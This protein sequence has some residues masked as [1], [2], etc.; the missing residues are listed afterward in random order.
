MTLIGGVLGRPLL[1][2]WLLPDL[3][4]ILNNC[5]G[6]NSLWLSGYGIGFPTRLPWF[7][8]GLNVIFLP[9]IYSFLSLL[10]TFF[11]RTEFKK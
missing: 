8:P 11:V 9:C 2:A 1:Q 10:R 7:K 4:T 3:N 6:Q 5:I